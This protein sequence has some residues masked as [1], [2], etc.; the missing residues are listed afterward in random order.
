M[1]TN[2]EGEAMK[3]FEIYDHF[4]KDAEWC[5]ENMKECINQLVDAEALLTRVSLWEHS[6]LQDVTCITL[7]MKIQRLYDL[8]QK[9]FDR[10]GANIVGMK[11]VMD[12]LS[13]MVG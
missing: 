6:P 5:N 11:W 12:M 1:E 9:L 13:M 3:L 8:I 2:F 4:K 10:E 7:N